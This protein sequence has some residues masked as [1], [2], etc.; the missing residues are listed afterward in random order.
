MPR[1]K[2]K[3]KPS[4]PPEM[5]AVVKRLLEAKPLRFDRVKVDKKKPGRLLDNPHGESEGR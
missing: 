1:K 2:K 3:D 5:D 4:P